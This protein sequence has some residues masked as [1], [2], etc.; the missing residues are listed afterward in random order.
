MHSSSFLRVLEKLEHGNEDTAQS[1]WEH[2]FPKLVNLARRQLGNRRRVADEEDVALSAFNSFWNGAQA[3][4][5]PN[6]KSREDLWRLLVTIT[7]RKAIDQVNHENRAKR[8]GGHV[9]GD[10]AFRNDSD[11]GDFG[12]DAVV[13]EDATAEQAAILAEEFERLIGMLDTDL[14]QIA[15]KRMEGYTSNEIAQQVGCARITIARAL[16]RIREIWSEEI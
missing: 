15:M 12:L 3:G 16:S 13:G 4:R 9:R 6:L 2:Y 10:S 1:L 8:G 5:F 14:A 7:L 11:E